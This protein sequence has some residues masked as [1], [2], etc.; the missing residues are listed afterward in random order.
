MSKQK[1]WVVDDDPV[2][3]RIVALTIQRINS[4]FEIE[5][6]E[7]GKTALDRFTKLTSG[8]EIMPAHLFVDLNMPIMGGWKFVSEVDALIKKSDFKMPNVYMTSSTF[9]TYDISKVD[10]YTFVIG[11]IKKPIS[12]EE[13]KKLLTL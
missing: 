13:M 2:L 6:M 3:R 1:I 8:G 10:E 11:L 4:S 7:N 5:E 9:K 12:V